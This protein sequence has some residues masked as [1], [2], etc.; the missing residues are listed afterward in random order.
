MTVKD[1]H[2]TEVCYLLPIQELLLVLVLWYTVLIIS[3]KEEQ[4]LLL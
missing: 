1:F 3:S 4:S 2:V